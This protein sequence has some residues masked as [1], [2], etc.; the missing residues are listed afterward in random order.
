[1]NGAAPRRL[2]IT[3]TDGLAEIVLDNPAG[4]NRLDLTAAAALED[5]VGVAAD[6]SVRCV[7]ITATGPRFCVGGDLTAFADTDAAA[8]DLYRS[9][10]R[11]ELVLRALGDLPKPVVIGVHGAVA[12][13]GL[14]F[15]LN[16]DLVVAARSTRFVVGYAAVG[17]TP[18]CGVSYLLPRV[19]GQRRALQIMLEGTRIDAAHALEWGLVTDVVDDA[20]LTSHVVALGQRLAAGP[21]HAFAQTKRLVR[22][23]WES[24]RAVNAEDE[25]RTIAAAL[26]TAEAQQRIGAFLGTAR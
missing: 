8:A 14:S 5:A 19:I 20:R 18:D 21:T 10:V 23:S 17:L 11:T 9:A 12:G 7:V 4:S 16:A 2:R 25:A 24:D 6:P 13:A 15:V 22:S 3:V 1:V 26:R